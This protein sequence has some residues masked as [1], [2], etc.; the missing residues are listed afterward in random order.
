MKKARKI[1]LPL[2]CMLVLLVALLGLSSCGDCKHEWTEGVT[3]NAGCTHDGA[4]AYTCKK[5]GEIKTELI[6]KT[7]H[8]F[9]NYVD[10]GNATC[11]AE[12]TKTATCDNGCGAT[13]MQSVPKRHNYGAEWEATKDGHFHVCPD[14]EG[15]TAAEAHTYGADGRCTVCGFFEHTHNGVKVEA[16][17]ATCTEEGNIL[18]W[19]C[20]E[21]GKNF[22]D[23]ACTAE[24][25]T[26]V[27]IGALGHRGVAVPAKDAA[28]NAVGN[29]ACYYCG[30]CDKYFSDAA[31]TQPLADADRILP[32]IEHSYSEAWSIDASGHK[33]VCTVCGAEQ[34]D[35]F[36][37]HTS[38][39]AATATDDEVCTVCGYIIAPALNHT[40]TPTRVEAKAATCTEAGNVACWYCEGCGKYFTSESC[41]Q[42][43]SDGDRVIA[44]VGHSKN[45]KE[46]LDPTCTA[47]GYREHWYCDRCDKCFSDEA[48][49]H[50]VTA[51]SLKRAARHTGVVFVAAK[52][53]TCTKDGN[54]A[55][56][57]CTACG[58]FYSDSACTEELTAASVKVAKTGHSVAHVNAKAATCTEKGNVEYWKCEN[59]KKNYT[60]VDCDTEYSFAD[61]YTNAL[62]HDIDTA[63]PILTVKPTCQN[64]GYSVYKCKR[65]GCSHEVKGSETPSV[66][67]DEHEVSRIPSTCQT[68]GSVTVECRYCHTQ[69]TYALPKADHSF[70]ETTVNP[71]CTEAG[72]VKHYCTTEG[73]DYYYKDNETAATG[74]NYVKDTANSTEPNCTDEGV[75]VYKC[76][77]GDSYTVR[78][79][80]NGHDASPTCEK[81]AKCKN[82]DYVAPATGHDY[83]AQEVKAPTCTEDGY[84]K[85]TCSHEGCEHPE[86]K[87]FNG[88]KTGHKAADDAKWT[89]TEKAV[90]G[91]KCT[92]YVE[93]TA[94]CAACG[95]KVTRR[96]NEYTKHSYKVEITTP[97][98]CKTKGVKTY[99]C[100]ECGESYTEDIEINPDAHKWDG[101]VLQSDGVTT[102]YICAECGEQKKSVSAKENT[103]AS[104]SADTVKELDDIELKNATFV[105]DDDIKESLN[106]DV[107]LKA[108]KT[109]AEKLEIPED[110]AERIGDAPIYN[111]GMTVDGNEVSELGGKMTV[112]IPYTL[113]DGEDPDNII[114]WY[115]DGDGA[116]EEIKA[117]Y[118]VINGEG[119]AE[120]ETEHFSYYTVTRMTPAERCKHYGHNYS[121]EIE[122]SATC[123]TGGYTMQI[124]M[125]CGNIK[126]V[127]G[128]ETDPLGHE[129]EKNK[130]NSKQVSCTEDGKEEFECSRC[131]VTYEVVT[132]CTGHDW[133]LQSK[134]AATCTDTGSATYKCSRCE[135]T[136]TEQ[137]AKAKHNYRSETVAPTCTESGYTL[138]VCRDCGCES[139][140]NLVAPLGHD[141]AEK[142]VNPTCIEGG[143]TEHYCKRCEE[144]FHSDPTDKT[145]AHTYNTEHADCENDKAC[146]Y[147]GLVAE[148]AT[149]HSYGT[150]GKC[151]E[152]GKKCSHD[153]KK[154]TDADGNELVIAATCQKAKHKVEQCSICF[155]TRDVEFEGS[156]A[157]HTFENGVCTSCGITSGNHYLAM[158]TTWKNMDGVALKLTGFTLNVEELVDS[159]TEWYVKIEAAQ[160]SVAEL[161][162]YVDAN[163]KLAGAF[164]GSLSVTQRSFGTQ[165]YAYTVSGVI[166]NGSIY[167]QTEQETGDKGAKEIN[168][169]VITTDAMI[170]SLLSSMGGVDKDAAELVIGW[171]GEKLVPLVEDFVKN[172]ADTLDGFIGSLVGMLFTEQET[173]DGYAY[174]FD[175]DKLREINA[176][177]DELKMSDFTDKY[178]GDGS[179]S[180]LYGGIE[181]IL[182]CEL[183]DSLDLAESFGI[184]AD[185]LADAVNS[186]VTLMSG[187]NGFDLKALIASD[188]YAGVTLGM[189]LFGAETEEDVEN[190]LT[191][192]NAVLD[193]D[194][195]T[196]YSIIENI[197]ESM[198][199]GVTGVEG[200]DVK[201]TVDA[202]I[203]FVCKSVAFTYE[204]DAQGTLTSLKFTLKDFK[205]DVSEENR[206]KLSL[207]VSVIPSGRITVDF[208]SIITEINEKASFP[209][210]GSDDSFNYNSSSVGGTYECIF[211]ETT[212]D[213]SRKI[214]LDVTKIH[215]D[216][217][218]PIGVTIMYNCGDSYLS[219]VLYECVVSK[220]SV[221]AY[222]IE[223]GFIL[224]NGDGGAM[225]LVTQNDDGDLLCTVSDGTSFTVTVDG[226]DEDYGSL[227]ELICKLIP[228]GWYKINARDY[229]TTGVYI[230]YNAETEEYSL[231]D[232]S[233]ELH[234]YV[235]DEEKSVINTACGTSSY[236][237]Y[238]CTECGDVYAEFENNY[239]NHC[240]KYVLSEGSVSCEDGLDMYE[241][242]DLCGTVFNIEENESV[243]HERHYTYTY[244]ETEK[245]LYEIVNC[246]CGEE[247][248]KSVRVTLDTDLE[249]TYGYYSMDH[250]EEEL[251]KFTP[252]VSGTYEFMSVE[253]AS[254]YVYDKNGS[255]LDCTYGG[256]EK[257]SLAV[258]YEL[259]AGETYY[260][261]C[262]GNGATV[263]IKLRG[264]TTVSLSDYGCTCGA[265][266]TVTDDF[267]IKSYELGECTCGLEGY[268]DI[269]TDKDE[270]CNRYEEYTV[271]FRGADGA[272]RRYSLYKLYNGGS[273]HNDEYKYSSK[274]EKVLLNGTLVN[275]TTTVYCYVCEDCGKETYRSESVY[276]KDAKTGELLG[277]KVTYISL[278]CDAYGKPYVYKTVSVEEYVVVT[279]KNG[280]T[281]RKSSYSS[282]HEY[283]DGIL[284]YYNVDK[285]TY[286]PDDPCHVTESLDTSYGSVENRD[287]YNHNST[288]KKI[289]SECDEYTEEVNGVKWNVTVTAKEYYC[290]HCYASIRKEVVTQRVNADETRRETVYK[291]YKPYAESATDYGY[292]LAEVNEY[293]NGIYS[294][295][296]GNTVEYPITRKNTYY[297]YGSEY[298]GGVDVQWRK[299]EYTYED[300]YC[301]YVSKATSSDS[302][303]EFTYTGESHLSTYTEYVLANGSKTCSDGIIM[304]YCCA[305]CGYRETK[306]G[307]LH[308][309]CDGVMWDIPATVYDL[310]NYGF[311]CGGSVEVR[312]CA[313]GSRTQVGNLMFGCDLVAKD[314]E[315]GVY[316]EYEDGYGWKTIYRCGVTDPVVCDGVY[317][318][319][320]GMRC[321]S[322]CKEYNYTEYV[323]GTGDDALRILCKEYTGTYRH[324]NEETSGTATETDGSYSVSLSWTENSCKNCGAKVNRTEIR[325]YTDADGK[326]VKET[327]T[328]YNYDI[329]SNPTAKNYEERLPYAYGTGTAY[330]TLVSYSQTWYYGAD[331]NVI[332]WEK[333]EYDRTA[334]GCIQYPKVTLTSSDGSNDY[335]YDNGHPEYCYELK[336]TKTA[337]TCTQYGEGKF[338]CPY[339]ND[340]KTKSLSPK[341]HSFLWNGSVYVCDYCGLENESGENG[342]V[343]LEDLSAT[344]GGDDYYV[345]GYWMKEAADPYF[346]YFM[347]RISIMVDGIDVALPMDVEY[348][349][350]TG[351]NNSGY[352][353]MSIA[354]IAAA[355]EEYAE[356]CEA[357]YSIYTN[358]VRI[359]FVPAGAGGDFDYAI[360]FDVLEQSTAA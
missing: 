177:L 202:A 28:C 141:M 118:V 71:T 281:V 200:F 220:A 154:V 264:S 164:C 235:L 79:A 240:T 61:L 111:F 83:K 105:P 343:I 222:V 316:Q 207:S 331:G 224:V 150:D 62:G 107:E 47:D 354:D 135:A 299:E 34:P 217:T 11:T 229:R 20:A 12:G 298:E 203:D 29:V 285:Y 39:G 65:T 195:F 151:T 1:I 352:I 274:T 80:A 166:E 117:K 120:F 304:S 48:M 131:H 310:K 323:F 247:Y 85:Y 147:C 43:I 171:A 75:T 278:C 322:K 272:T 345:M 321:D 288:Y 206:I 198:V 252:A 277:E 216:Y 265:T 136:K 280:D 243:V 263:K 2:L 338:V 204:T 293:A 112:R 330:A 78:A 101:G 133:E 25:K 9:T 6:S 308:T 86:I 215:V 89:D 100:T 121:D 139:K 251:F 194:G 174:S 8:S 242:C 124:C 129:F 46:T 66:E 81:S 307:V 313:C 223:D 275:V 255:W 260:I 270:N 160:L 218:D 155:G 134:K 149:G 116:V 22:S 188:N 327:K 211:N 128:S 130:E 138:N 353:K 295:E 5:C 74:H 232:Y 140:A 262:D 201:A 286:D 190:M 96:G 337:P 192:I 360:T 159:N 44:A 114:V 50:E 97:A 294:L 183:A 54:K 186:F 69:R 346:N 90:E 233:Y 347:I 250:R 125:R 196:L 123:L 226:I 209:D 357:S 339:C 169:V 108:D 161:M 214:E 152:C 210:M 19:H 300:D 318:C 180:K 23:A 320:Y 341:E 175:F 93:S 67:C 348:T 199:D 158:V 231:V 302:D 237:H 41:T 324:V 4:T 59:C 176:D 70:A 291:T 282:E 290:L 167:V 142:T 219:D 110:V 227:S 193:G 311:A 68:A 326:F 16:R 351:E 317:T 221:T 106:G 344:L 127:E 279:Y 225:A 55:Y 356:M 77:C 305:V 332:R 170:A 259:E 335:I 297:I 267:D 148:K 165:K 38:G 342:S 253:Y 208:D 230:L 238:V 249:L 91:K 254:V 173:E 33:H 244:D 18:Y 87:E 241:Y 76:A 256:S 45:H 156:P 328:V 73:C 94:D 334:N 36:A 191:D 52:A 284:T 315:N 168:S 248:R 126:I 98:T 82:C 181:K 182:T 329:D 145:D 340:V 162:L 296:N 228:S 261:S 303:F 143:Y 359:S 57:S 99:T 153:Y 37:S 58:K 336:E 258:A 103:S 314:D 287:Y 49:L 132:A 24:I 3:V 234:N 269:L 51:E 42:Y 163:G 172:N 95:E 119:Y 88:A 257:L 72:Y 276:T 157:E 178:F 35:S 144:S 26:S 266:M 53:A 312:T 40:H 239:H 246:P 325:T 273:E 197:I 146:K 32:M 63:N 309:S 189:L 179:Y 102:L 271:A 333:Y 319:E 56:Y 115:I 113:A 109:S 30:S 358:P 306:D 17:G 7:G 104:A 268:L 27:A 349:T 289:P 84:I 205:T 15:T 350:V 355:I 21:C 184:D 122:V 137:L 185:L 245:T 187:S 292:K 64:K 14:C 60:S 212:Y 236:L 31:C 301:H 10:D 283:V 92:F 213:A 13:D